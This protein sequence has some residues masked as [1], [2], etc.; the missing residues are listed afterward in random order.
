VLLVGG[1]NGLRDFLVSGVGLMQKACSRVCRNL[2]IAEWRATSANWRADP[3]AQGCPPA[4]DAQRPSF[5][6]D[7][8]FQTIHDVCPSR[9][10]PDLL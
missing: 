1:V 5:E 8:S 9:F 2:T 10:R 7:G 3:P 4:D 6:S